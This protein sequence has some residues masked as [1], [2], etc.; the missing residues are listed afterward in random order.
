[1]VTSKL[2]S[3][4]RILLFANDREEMRPLV[5]TGILVGVSD[6]TFLTTLVEF[7]STLVEFLLRRMLVN[8]AARAILGALETPRP[9]GS[10]STGCIVKDN[11]GQVCVNRFAKTGR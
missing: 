11:A 4:E 6:V 8:D 5:G 1:M 7:L 9:T 2:V 3:S 10:V